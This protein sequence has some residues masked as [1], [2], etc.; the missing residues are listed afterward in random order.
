MRK[1]GCLLLS[2]IFAAGCSGKGGEKKAPLPVTA[3]AVSS[4]ESASSLAYTANIKPATQVDLAFRIG[5]YV[6]SVLMMGSGASARKIQEGDFVRAGTVLVRL[7]SQDYTDKLT[8]AKGQLG[9]AQAYYDNTRK[10]FERA[11]RLYEKNSLTKPEMDGATAK[12]EAASA[13]LS[14]ATALVGE[15]ELAFGDSQLKSPIDGVVLRRFSEPGDLAGPGTPAFVLADLSSVKAVFGVPDS[16]VKTLRIGQTVTVVVDTLPN[17]EFK[18]RLARINPSADMQGRVF[19]VEVRIPNHSG[20]LKPGMVGTISLD[21]DRRASRSLYIPIA[22]ITKP[23][24]GQEGYAVYVI[25]KGTDGTVARM[26]RV[27]TGG[28]SGNNVEVRSGLKEGE[29]VILKGATIAAD[30]QPVQVTAQ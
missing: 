27:E 24:G 13:K 28:F 4:G 29:L 17:R 2:V 1:L 20:E 25:E 11:T 16:V 6:D 26:R 19:D 8:Q 15:A 9:E 23:A 7:R 21:T 5:G 14:A 30:G 12:F 22:A 3:A 18:A 10:E